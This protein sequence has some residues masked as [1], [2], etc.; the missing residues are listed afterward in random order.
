LEEE[1]EGE[2]A[3]KVRIAGELAE[4]EETFDVFD[5]YSGSRIERLSSM[6]LE[7]V[8]LGA[9]V[10]CKEIFG[11]VSLL[12]KFANMEEAVHLSNDTDYGLQTGIFTHRLDNAI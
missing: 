1:N 8:S 7:N 11:P 2:T 12:T 10:S 3:F 9:K 4:R 6:R 5:K